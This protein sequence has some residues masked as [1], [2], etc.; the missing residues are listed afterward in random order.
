[1]TSR[2]SVTIGL[3]YTFFRGASISLVNMIAILGLGLS[4]GILFIVLAVINGFDREFRERI[5]GVLPHIEYLGS[6]PFENNKKQILE[7]EGLP[8]IE[9]IAPIIRGGGLASVPDATK[10]VLILGI[11]ARR[12]KEVSDVSIYTKGKL[13]SQAGGFEVALGVGVSLALN[14]G[15]GDTINL[16]LPKTTTTPWGLISRQKRFSVVGIVDS[17]SMLDSRSVY[18]QI[19]DAQ[20]FFQLKNHIHGYQLKLEDIFLAEE[21]AEYGLNLLDDPSLYS[22][23]WTMSYGALYEA[24]RTQKSMMFILLSLLIG[25]AAFNLVSTLVMSVDQREGEVAIF[26]TMGADNAFL[27]RVFLSLTIVIAILGISLGL[28]LGWIIA[29]MLPHMYEWTAVD[30][31]SEYFVRYLPV[32]ILGQDIALIISISFLLCLLSAIYPSIKVIGQEP[33]EVLSHE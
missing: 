2:L 14:V 33:A 18:I 17:Q 28:L 29:L 12:Y 6:S 5:L 10:G 15:I 16:T 13:P 4:V 20:A 1:M 11:D 8:N 21:T 22:R 7:L 26:R 27:V 25:V 30:L 31:M 19:E 24:I 9:G 32:E 3:R 23:P